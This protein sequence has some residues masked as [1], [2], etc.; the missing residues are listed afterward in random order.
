MKLN[1]LKIIRTITATLEKALPTLAQQWA[2]KL[3]FSPRNPKQEIPD[4]PGLQ[5]HWSTSVVS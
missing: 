4:I 1:L 2:N 5:Q 3:F